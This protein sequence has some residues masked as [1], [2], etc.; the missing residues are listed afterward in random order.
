MASHLVKPV[1]PVCIVYMCVCVCH[2]CVDYLRDVVAET[3]AWF[4]WRP[5]GS[6]EEELEFEGHT[7]SLLSP[8]QPLSNVDIVVY[9]VCVCVCLCVSLCVLCTVYLCPEGVPCSQ[10]INKSIH[11]L[12]LSELRLEGP[13]HSVPYYQDTSCVCANARTCGCA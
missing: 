9:L 8:D 1:N 11:N 10:R 4:P 2:V 12:L 7:L 13:E 6:L 3:E 5:A